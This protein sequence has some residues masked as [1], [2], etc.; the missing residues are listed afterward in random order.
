MRHPELLAPA[1]D[2]EKLEM[3]LAYGADAVYLGG[4]HFGLRAFAGNFGLAQ[5]KEAKDL[6]HAAG[7]KLYLTLNAYLRPA[8]QAELSHYLEELRALDLDAYI[9]ADPGVLATVRR[10]DPGRE[11][12][13][14]TQANTTSG[15][16]AEFWRTAGVRRVN[17]ARELTLEEIR[18]V[19]DTTTAELEV[20]IHGAQCVAYSGRC[21]LSAALVDRS[22]NSGLCAQSCR[23]KYALVEETR[24]GEYMPVEE[25]SRGSYILNSKDLCLI[26]YLPQLVDAGVDSLKIEGRM[27]GCYYVAAVTRVYRAALD[28]YLAD[29]ASYRCDP[30]WRQELEKVSHRPY[31]S[32]FL[33]EAG[34][35][36]VHSGDSI[37]RR[38]HDFVGVVRSVSEDGR[39]VVEGRNRFFPGEELE[40]IG[41]GMRQGSFCVGSLASE[42]EQPLTV[43][44]PNSQIVMHLPTGTQPGDLL[45]RQVA[46]KK[47]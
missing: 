12:H 8:E 7:K 37:Y 17:L 9:V 6:V 46:A 34:N 27:K 22:A 26:D 31:G 3:A 24:P 41:P 16:A 14:S 25:D 44:Q 32:G 43:A 36:Q 30:S 10:V 5:L 47:G 20:F 45:R 1:G 40:L 23:W 33:T 18:R 21:L 19:R 2:L 35:A 38:S 42:K 29:P 28:C 13:L 15:T 11:L 4:D 39:G